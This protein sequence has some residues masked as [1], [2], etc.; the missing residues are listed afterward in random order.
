MFVLK[1]LYSNTTK[2]HTFPTEADKIASVHAISNQEFYSRIHDYIGWVVVDATYTDHDFVDIDNQEVI[3]HYV[4]KETV[5]STQ[6]S[7]LIE[8]FYYDIS[9]IIGHT[10]K[11]IGLQDSNQILECKKFIPKDEPLFEESINEYTKPDLE[12]IPSFELIW[13]SPVFQAAVDK[14]DIAEVKQA[15]H[16]IEFK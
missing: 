9:R 7:T 5:R 12:L 16:L 14:I 11:A 4:W 10:I 1:K 6:L 15:K 8:F 2:P 13:A 3:A